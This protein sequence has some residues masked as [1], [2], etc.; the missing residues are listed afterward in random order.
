MF[1]PSPRPQVSEGQSLQPVTGL[2]PKPT[3]QRGQQAPAQAAVTGD[4]VREALP[5]HSSTLTGPR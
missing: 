5:S 2:A 4:E 3:P 1:C